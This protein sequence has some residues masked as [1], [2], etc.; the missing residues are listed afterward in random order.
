MDTKLKIPVVFKM[1]PELNQEEGGGNSLGR[2][3]W[4]AAISPV[5]FI[6]HPQLGIWGKQ[7]QLG[8]M[9]HNHFNLTLGW[10][11]HLPLG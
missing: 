4:L 5:C 2:V 11:H 10:V 9:G 6:P 8:K 3:K 1:A 7:N